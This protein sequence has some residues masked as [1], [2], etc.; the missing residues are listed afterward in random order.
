MGRLT[1][2]GGGDDDDIV[3]LLVRNDSGNLNLKVSCLLNSIRY[4][5]TTTVVFILSSKMLVLPSLIIAL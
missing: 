2:C 3:F 4:S 1:C 5:V